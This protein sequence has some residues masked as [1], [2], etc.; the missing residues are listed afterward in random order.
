MTY[1]RYNDV[2]ELHLEWTSLCNAR[3][4]QCARTG[5]ESLPLSNLTLEQIKKYFPVDFVSN[6]ESM[7]SC[8]NY[9]DP[10]VNPEC[11][12]IVKYFIDNGCDRV[13]LHTNGGV[14][15]KEFWTELGKTGIR[16][17]FAID[18][19]EDTNH[20]Y[21][22]GV[23]WERLM[24]NVKTFIAA[25]GNATWAFLLFAHNEHQ[26]EEARQLSIDLGFRRFIDKASSRFVGKKTK[27]ISKKTKQEIKE[28]KE[29]QKHH[30]AQETAIQTYGSWEEY[31]A[32]TPITCKTLNAKSVYVDFQGIV[33]PCCWMGHTFGKNYNIKEHL[34]KQYGTY[35]IASLED[36]PLRDIL[37]NTEWF[38]KDLAETWQPGAGRLYVCSTTCGGIY[39]PSHYKKD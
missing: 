23:R 15:D 16:V 19:L 10:I 4:P 21:R 3:C 27:V 35:K 24:E 6:L 22:E 12:E 36:R 32:Q 30:K 11:V 20:I 18:G 39:K 28:S 1:V 37:D 25:G 14:R 5:N 26:V 29:S 17:V 31:L 2:K 9:G 34:E 8:G 33:Y 38:N 7:Y 13:A